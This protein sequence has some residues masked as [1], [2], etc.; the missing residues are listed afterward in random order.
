MQAGAV[1]QN[2]PAGATNWVGGERPKV[3]CPTLPPKRTPPEVSSGKSNYGISPNLR[4]DCRTSKSALLNL[5][6]RTFLHALVGGPRIIIRA[7]LDSRKAYVAY[8]DSV[9]SPANMAQKCV[10]Q[11][12]GKSFTDP[13]AEDCLYHSGPPVFHEGQKGDIF[14]NISTPTNAASRFYNS[15]CLKHLLFG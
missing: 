1:P 14:R 8:V 2:Q 6:P 13:D 5:Q 15:I 4:I 11:G 10:H 3:G 7:F 9:I 12:C